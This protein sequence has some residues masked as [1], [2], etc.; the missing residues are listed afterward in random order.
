MH[1]ANFS[2]RN[3]DSKNKIGCVSTGGIHDQY[4]QISIYTKELKLGLPNIYWCTIFGEDYIESIGRQKLS[5]C[6]VHKIQWLSDN[7]VMLQLTESVNDSWEHEA[8]FENLRDKVKNYLGL[9]LFQP[10][11]LPTGYRPLVD[12]LNERSAQNRKKTGPYS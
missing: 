12:I 3:H 4:P 8:E 5:E 6:P 10:Q 9:N 11:S 7:L 1:R 2:E